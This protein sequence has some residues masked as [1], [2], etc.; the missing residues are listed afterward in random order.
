MAEAINRQLG[1]DLV[2][3]PRSTRGHLGLATRFAIRAGATDLPGEE[4]RLRQRRR[5]HA[6]RGTHEQG[7][8]GKRRRLLALR[9]LETGELDR[10]VVHGSSCGE[11]DGGAQLELR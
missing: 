10:A 1:L 9:V 4:R 7:A 2:A 3:S 8:L 11:I 5:R 6:F